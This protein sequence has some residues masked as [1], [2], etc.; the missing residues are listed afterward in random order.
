[1]GLVNRH[2]LQI[3]R[4]AGIGVPYLEFDLVRRELR[5]KCGCALD[6]E[7]KLQD[8]TRALGNFGGASA[9]AEQFSPVLCVVLCLVEQV[10][11]G[12]C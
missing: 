11:H 12:S 8:M 2:I 9:G 4:F 1:M 3:M 6:C 5:Y 7:P 10:G